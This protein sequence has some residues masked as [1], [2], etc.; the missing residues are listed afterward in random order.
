M[1]DAASPSGIDVIRVW[2]LPDDFFARPDNASYEGRFP[3]PP[4]T[5]AREER[6]ARTAW[7]EA[8]DGKRVVMVVGAD[9]SDGIVAVL[10]GLVLRQAVEAAEGTAD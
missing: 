8:S 1:A 5:R 10:E 7:E 9:H 2:A 4:V 6:L 3:R